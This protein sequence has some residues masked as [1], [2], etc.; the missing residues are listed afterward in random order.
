[1]QNKSGQAL[2]EGYKQ[3]VELYGRPLK[4]PADMC[5]EAAARICADTMGP[6][7]YLV[8]PSAAQVTAVSIFHP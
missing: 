1:M 8:G 7:S 3:A 2:L 6:T 5:L 4:L